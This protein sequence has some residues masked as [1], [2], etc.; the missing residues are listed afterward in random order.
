MLCLFLLIFSEVTKYILDYDKLIYNSLAE[1]LS[2]NQIRNYLDLQ[3]KCPDCFGTFFVV[4]YSG[5]YH[6]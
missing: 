2:Y 1:S 3:Q 5:K 6:C 4:M